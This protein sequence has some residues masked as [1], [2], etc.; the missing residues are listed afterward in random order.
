MLGKYAIV[1]EHMF[2]IILS[3]FFLRKHNTPY[4]LGNYE[5]IPLIWLLFLTEF[6][7]T[8]T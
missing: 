5:N 1:S 8:T 2:H 4:R 7:G 3:F 6:V